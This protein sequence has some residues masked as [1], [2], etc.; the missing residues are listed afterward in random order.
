MQGKTVIITGANSG[1][2]K[3]TAIG[4]ARRGAHIVMQF[5]KRGAGSSQP[6]T[7]RPTILSQSAQRGNRSMTRLLLILPI[8][9]MLLASS[10]SV[11][12]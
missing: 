3:A 4:L 2:G 7:G 9:G 10:A 12:V 8:V 11:S 5:V 6:L 1:I